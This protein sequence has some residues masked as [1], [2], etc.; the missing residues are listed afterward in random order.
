MN[1]RLLP[2]M[3][4]LLLVIVLGVYYIAFDVLRYRV[5]SQPFVVTVLMPS[6][7]G[8]YGGANVTYRGVQ[9]GTVTA[10][11]LSA[12]D[13]AVKM[14]IYPGER[15]PDNG[16]VYVKELSAL[17]EQYLD[18]QPASGSGS[19]LHNGTVIPASRVVLP[20][21][22][23]AALI[24][25][26]T[27]LNSIN[28]TSL[29]TVESF[30][31][32][33]FVGTGPGLRS[34]IVTGQQLFGALVAAQPE[35]V[36]LVV[37]GRTNLKTLQA[38]DSDLATFTSGLASLTAQLRNSNSD[39]QALIDNSVAAEQQLNPFLTDNSADISAAIANLAADAK[40][41]NQFQPEVHAIFELLPFVSDDLAA[42]VSG[43]QVHGVLDINT[44]ETVCPYILGSQMP[45]PTE[46]VTS[47]A[48]TNSCTATAPDMLRRGASS[49]P[50]YA[51][52]TGR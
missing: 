42:V 31:T 44:D 17:G 40:V 8:L 50:S 22:I 27:L 18:L 41:S 38:T 13:V 10:L 46:T 28:P 2:R 26:G 25:L 4:A 52:A 51:G 20:V 37:D 30:L 19:D 29:Q 47:A 36:N 45:G 6:A 39:L 23:G 35:T 7:G 5:A 15:I 3:I 12:G 49:T 14:G 24:D 32:T 21:P 16:P 48:L 11:D 1:R 9:V 33:A 34:I 43:G